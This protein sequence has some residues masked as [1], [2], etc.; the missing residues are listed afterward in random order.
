[1]VAADEYQGLR[2]DHLICNA[3][4]NA[5]FDFLLWSPVTMTEDAYD[6]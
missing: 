4:V 5:H 2:V 6:T 3:P 1:M